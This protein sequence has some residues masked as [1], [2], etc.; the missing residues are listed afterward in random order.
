MTRHTRHLL[1]AIPPLACVLFL[2]LGVIPSASQ[3]RGGSAGPGR[4]SVT[5]WGASQQAL[6]DTRITNATVRMIARVTIPGDAV[7]IR[8]DNTF[9]AEP[10]TIGRAYVGLRIQGAAVAAG[11]NHSLSFNGAA[12]VSIA[13]GGSAWSDP[14]QLSVLA[15]QDLAVSLYVPGSNVRPSQHTAAAVSS[16]RSADG[17]GA[18]EESRAPFTLTTTA[19]WWLKAIDVE[20]VSP[21]GAIVAFGDSITDGTC[22]TLDAHDRWED[23]VSMRLGLADEAGLPRRDGARGAQK[24]VVN[25]GIGGNTITR[26]GLMPPADSTPGLERFERDVLSHHGVSDVVLFMGTNDIRRGAPAAQ[27]IAGMTSIIQRIKAKGIKAIGV[28]I[29]PRHNVAPNG[30][31]TGWNAEKTRIRNEVNQW[32]RSK[33]PFDALI[34]FDK[35]VRD[36]SNP[37]LI[38]PPF[39]CGDG[40]HPSPAGYFAM[41]TAVDLSLFRTR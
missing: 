28:T 4:T 25:E 9:G 24:A 20:S 15:Q 6:A 17:S 3:G 23:V 38:H 41:G 14:V 16:Y 31:N 7:R 40:I 33:A 5:A 19:L 37:D 8:L 1:N 10:V 21:P 34:D 11:S 36:P 13:A 35:V 32:I 39:N 29:I 30:T 22:S 12:G 2:M 27:V 26:D 18:S